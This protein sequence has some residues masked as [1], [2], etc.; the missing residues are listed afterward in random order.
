[1]VE[2]GDRAEGD[3][4]GRVIIDFFPLFSAYMFDFLDME[5]LDCTLNWE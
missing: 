5:I 2:M 3:H 4:I 1:M